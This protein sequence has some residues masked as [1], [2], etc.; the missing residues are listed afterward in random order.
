MG[1]IQR[2]VAASQP[3]AFISA[4]Y[5]LDKSATYQIDIAGRRYPL[6]PYLHAPAQPEQQHTAVAGTP[7]NAYYKPKVVKSKRLPI[8][9]V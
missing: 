6:T 1:F 4:E 5:I 8:S 2:A 9:A 7:A 3:E